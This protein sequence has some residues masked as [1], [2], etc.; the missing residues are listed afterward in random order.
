MK[1]FRM[2]RLI[3]TLKF[4]LKFNLSILLP[5]V[6]M[7]ISAAAGQQWTAV[8]R[9]QGAGECERLGGGAGVDI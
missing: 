2:V 4:K 8:C 6:K 1:T 3:Q 5:R 7:A 9:G